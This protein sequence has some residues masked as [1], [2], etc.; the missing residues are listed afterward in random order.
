VTTVEAS[1]AARLTGAVDTDRLVRTATDL[2]NIPSPTGSEQAAAEY[3]RDCLAAH[4]L[5]SRLQQVE[6]G[7]ANALGRLAGA[8]GGTSLM[9]NGHLDT[10]YS[11]S[12]PWL[13]G[14]GFKPAA[15]VTDGRIWGLGI[16][17]M[18]GAVACYL[19]VVRVLRES[20]LRLRGD[21]MV[22]GVCGEIEKTQFS[23]EFSGA[24]YRG[25]GAGSRF[26]AMFGGAEA[27][28]C[29]LGEPTENKVVTGHFGTLWARLSVAGPFVHTA[30]S[31]GRL[32]E[33][34]IVRLHRAMPSILDWIGDWAERGAEG[35]VPGIVNI[36]A[37]RGGFAWR[38]SRTPGQTDL[39][40]DIRVPP[41]MRVQAAAAHYRDLVRD[42]NAKFPDCA[43]SSELFVTAPGSSIDAG[44][45][46]VGAVERA[47]ASVFGQP[48]ERE[49]A[50]WYCD[51]AP[52]SRY[53]IA[54]VVY[55]ASSGL[56]SPQ[57]E[58]LSID[59][60]TATCQ[61]YLLA[62]LDICEVSTP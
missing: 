25:Y 17:N 50:S 22:A 52:L 35:P 61:A 58:N 40:L 15:V 27:D 59:E 60:L 20:G 62:A 54:T 16:A 19:E 41:S 23:D 26:L 1:L 9:F 47:H 31:G 57:G 42:L 14:V 21:L 24:Q 30:W 8:G 34:S 36:G 7:R 33:N 51:A 13:A 43:F 11:G 38:L 53:G 6:D 48:P 10:S 28:V 29:I 32:E 45:P 49:A 37:V 4:G 5:E 56:P 44:H 18:K 39:F 12:E 46:V 2:V 55:G 3:V